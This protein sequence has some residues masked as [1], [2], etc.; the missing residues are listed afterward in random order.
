MVGVALVQLDIHGQ[1]KSPSAAVETAAKV[2]ENLQAPVV[3]SVEA[4]TSG[5]SQNPLK[6]SLIPLPN[7]F[8]PPPF[9]YPFPP[10]FCLYL[11]FET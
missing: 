6:V 10:G 3:A 7:L 4:L 8:Q 2:V 5:H 1:A 11:F 9:I